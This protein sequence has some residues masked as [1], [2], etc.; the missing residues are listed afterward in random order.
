MNTY[1]TTQASNIAAIAGVIALVAKMFHKNIEQVDIETLL[2]SGLAIV[3]I[4]SNYIHRYKKG[5]LNVA[6]FRKQ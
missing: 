2:A 1:S 6:G 5:D 3:A 4:V